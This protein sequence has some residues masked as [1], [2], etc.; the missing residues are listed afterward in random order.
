MRMG[1]GHGGVAISGRRQSLADGVDVIDLVGELVEPR[2]S[3]IGSSARFRS[4]I[5]DIRAM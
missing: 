3:L 2:T 4:S 5:D 1:I